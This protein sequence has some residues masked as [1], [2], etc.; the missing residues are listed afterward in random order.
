[1]CSTIWG[2]TVPTVH[3]CTVSTGSTGSIISARS[4]LYRFYERDLWV[5]QDL[6][7]LWDL[8]FRTTGSIRCTE[9]MVSTGSMGSTRS[10]DSIHYLLFLHDV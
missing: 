5:L 3:S 1:M 6:Y 10:I 9:C 2:S 7:V 4:I 8:W